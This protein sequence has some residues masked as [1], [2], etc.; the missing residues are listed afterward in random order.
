MKKKTSVGSK[1]ILTLTM[2]FF[3]L[4]ILY[5]IIFSFN[6]SRSL[7]KFGGFSLRWYEKMFADSTMME[8]VL[9]TV[10]IAIIATVVATVAGTITAIGLSKSRKVVQKMVERINDLPVMNPDIVTAIS[11]LMFFSVL[12]VKKGFGTLLIAHIMF[13]IPYVMLSVTPKLRSL[14]PNLID[15]AMDL[16]ATPFQALAKVIVPQIKPGIVSGALIAFTM[17]FDDFVISYF[18]TGNGVNNIS[19]LVYTMSKRVN[20]SINALSTIVILLITLV[21]GV[22]N[23]V[24]IVREKR[25]KDG[26]SSRAVSRK[27][28]AAVA[29][30]LVLAVVGGTV[31]ARLSQQHKS[32]A[33]VEKYGSNVL[34]LYLPGEYL[35][36]NVIS[37]F[38]KQYGVRVIVENFDSNEMMYTKLMAGDRYDVI[39]PSDYMIERL[40]NEDFLQPLDKSMIPNMENMSDAVLGMSYDPD[41]TYSIPY[42]WGSVGLVYNHENV[43]PAVIESEGWEVLRNTDYAGHIYIYDSERDSFMMAFKA[44]GYSMNTEDPNEIN[45]AYEWLLQMNNTMSPVYVT[46]EVIDGMMNGYKDIAVVYSGDAAVVLDENEDMSFY[47]PSQG[48]NIWCDA[49]VIPANAENPKLAHEFINYMLTYEAAFDNTETVGYTSPNAEVFEEMT[50]SED[51][52]AD[53]AAYLPRSGYEKDEMFHD[54]QVLMRELSKLWIKVKA[55]K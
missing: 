37:D 41:N 1:I 40:M 42:F 11:L 49:M 13:C 34:K 54:N 29:A 30:V 48:T 43:D 3:Y 23:I 15:A 16:G 36:E 46:D 24:P 33:A 26:K 6:D 20:P 19:I 45:D 12:T 55:A 44:L 10:I 32:A 38:E 7:T 39:I 27:A 31:G 28:M 2:L 5:I 18:T 51:L 50:S 9:Y 52:Y 8:A 25:E 47:M 21:L 53:N 17:S 35:G 22:V 4:P 14:D